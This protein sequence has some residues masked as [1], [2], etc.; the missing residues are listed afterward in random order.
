MSGREWTEPECWVWEQIRA[1]KEADFNAREGRTNQFLAPIDTFVWTDNRKL[2]SSFLSEILFT[3]ALFSCIS[4]KGVRIIG[5]WFEDG[6]DLEAGRLN[7]DLWLEFCRFDE[8]A[9]LSGLRIENTLSLEGSFFSLPNKGLDIAYAKIGE[10]L[11]LSEMR[12]RGELKGTGLEV[13]KTP[14]LDGVFCDKSAI[15][16]FCKFG[17]DL[18]LTGSSF[19][20]NLDIESTEIFG[21]LLLDRSA[22]VG[23]SSFMASIKVKDDIFIHEA[24]FRSVNLLGAKVGND[25]TFSKSTISNELLMQSIE[26]MSLNMDSIIS[27]ELIDLINAKIRGGVKLSKAKIGGEIY[28]ALM[29]IAGS[30]RIDEDST[31]QSINLNSI[32]V[33]GD[34]LLSADVM[35]TLSIDCAQIA[36]GLF[37]DEGANLKD[38]HLASTKIRAQLNFSGSKVTGLLNMN[39]VEIGSSLIME[40][41]ASFGQ[42]ELAGAYI[43]RQVQLSGSIFRGSLS[44]ESIK[45]IDSILARDNCSFCSVNLALAQ[46]GRDIRFNGAIIDEELDLS[47]VNI[48]SEL[49]IEYC[50]LK[51]SLLAK[52]ARIEMNLFLCGNDLGSVNFSGAQIRGEL[53]LGAKV[54]PKNRWTTD[55]NPIFKLK[56]AHVGALQDRKDSWPEVIQL[57]G[58]VYDCL[59]GGDGEEGWILKDS[60]GEQG[61]FNMLTRGTEWYLEW[62]SRDPVYSPQPYVQLAETFKAAGDSTKSNSVLYD[63]CR[64]ERIEAWK[65]GRYLKW[66]GSMLLNITIGYGLG[67]RYFRVLVW[68]IMFASVG[69]LL[70]YHFDY[71]E[72]GFAQEFL[73]SFVYSL[74][75]LLPVVELKN[76]EGISLSGGI[77]LYFYFQKLLGWILGSFLV[78]GL[79]GLTQKR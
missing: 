71:T 66:L 38:V 8:S 42:V 41:K 68:V 65:K 6:I 60:E 27:P 47:G 64:R 75:V 43:G 15:L 3:E 28:M 73:N 46:V 23:G 4:R 67:G 58:F 16:D 48:T 37:L 1:G 53:C 72:N 29:D 14:F 63:S 74:D 26:A 33:G 56:N 18:K 32:R 70:L 54:K 9:N 52:F 21:S 22:K 45:V 2:S 77:E 51:G 17:G 44:M 31:F 69:A 62:L 25:I 24:N 61:D 78:A 79:A 50:V 34:V 35:G 7:F 10:I 13:A 20:E 39:S 19:Q 49:R 36:G 30:L 57:E 59:G 55:K 11:M 5:A 40:E 12:L 76:S